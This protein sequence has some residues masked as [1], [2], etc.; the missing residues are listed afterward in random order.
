MPAL[1]LEPIAMRHADLHGLGGLV[2]ARIAADGGVTRTAL[3]RDLSSMVAHKLSPAE[4]R[5]AAEAEIETLTDGG[6]IAEQRGRLHVTETG[7]IAAQRLTPGLKTGTSWTDM[8]DLGLAGHALG[9]DSAAHVKALAKPEALRAFIV[10]KAFGLPLK[11]NQSASRLRA[12]L[13]VV[14]L[15]RAFGNKI[16]RGL[17]TGS[18]VSAK[19]GRV[20]AGQ[21]SR[22]PQDYGTD[23]RLIA[24][25]AAEAAGSVQTDEDAVRLALIRGYVT[26]A[27]AGKASP[28]APASAPPAL[29]LVRP[30]PEIA[31]AP[32]A[33]NDTTPLATPPSVQAERPDMA[34]FVAA[35]Q[36]AARSRAEGWPG[37][38]KA[39]ISLVW[40][41]IRDSHRAWGI[42]EIEFKCMLAEAHRAGSIVLAN[43]DL[44]DKKHL[45]EFEESAIAYKNT[46]WHF[47][48]VEE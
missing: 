36:V 3:I 6:L 21:L 1:N 38:R 20:L 26:R 45:K 48:R 28:N 2:V 9:L 35:V 27:L 25:L 8:R 17:G 15:E 23:G 5:S 18:G 10:Q 4:W 12:Q 43:A 34:T 37:N 32:A 24:A 33:A 39:F 19:T 41:T 29:E 31:P 40:Q 30:R 16:K 7:K 42:S 14:A 44:K 22:R 13:A 46:V 47:V 11:A